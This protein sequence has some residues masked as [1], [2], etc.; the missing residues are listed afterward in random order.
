MTSETNRKCHSVSQEMAVTLYQTM[1]KIRRSEE[2][3]A[4]IYPTDKIQSPIHLSIGQEAVSSGVCLALE[5]S[6]HIY[7]TYRSHGLFIA[8]GGDLKGL[9]AELFAKDTG[10]ARG[11]GGSMHLVASEVG[12]MGCSALVASTIPVATGDALAS[13]NQGRKRVVV[14]SFGDGAVDEGIFFESLNF[15]ALKNLPIIFVCENNHYAVHSRVSDRH[16]E[17]HLYK[18]GESLGLSGARHNG[19]DVFEVHRSMKEA[20][21]HI[22]EGGSPLLLEYTTY[23]R[24]EHVGPGMDHL[25]AYRD[26][27]RLAD[28][29]KNDPLQGAKT[30]LQQQFQTSD[31]TFLLWEH[32]IQKEIEEAVAFA[33]ASPY[34]NADQLYEGLYEASSW[35]T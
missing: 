7:G 16:K 30:F 21:R 25:E 22:R 3:I 20:V 2:K 33:E 13:Q 23:R 15:A 24:F 4:E 27:R 19:D 12:L 1:L 34:P 32:T 10:C 35:E 11:K 14:A 31:E 26:Q 9:F 28:A 18:F 17:T 5:K 8:K 6:D 29:M